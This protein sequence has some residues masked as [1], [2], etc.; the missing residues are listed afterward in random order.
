MISLR[1]PP[2]PRILCLGAHCDDIDVGC[3]GTL[4]LLSEIHPQLQVRWIV[5]ASIPERADE[6]RAS[7]KRFLGKCQSSVEFHPFPDSFLPYHG[8]D[9]KRVFE[10]L[11]NDPSPDL[12]FTH[13][14]KDAHQDHRLVSELTWN[15]FRDH[16]ILEYEVPKWDGD[17]GQPNVFLPLSE[18]FVNKKVEYL[19]E[20][21][22]SQRE[23]HWFDAD[24][25][26]GLMR[27][28]GVESRAPER[29]AEAFYGRKLAVAPGA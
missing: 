21:Y 7:A 14:G 18:R 28:R 15:T 6:T 16:A 10:G 27:L 8:A 1:L 3:G 17:M 2:N 25:I 22:R 5:F 9:V 24:T 19:L 13:Y 29:F 23:K 12:I 4:L 26:R 11:K 20:S